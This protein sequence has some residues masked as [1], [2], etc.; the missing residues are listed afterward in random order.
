MRGVV[1]SG[2]IVHIPYIDFMYYCCDRD[3]SQETE[4]M[5]ILSNMPG[6]VKLGSN[7]PFTIDVPP[8]VT[9]C[10][11]CILRYSDICPVA[12]NLSI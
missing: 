4:Y 11:I 1:R 3:V 2:V 9:M 12:S 6:A 5:T 7:S 8:S 10:R